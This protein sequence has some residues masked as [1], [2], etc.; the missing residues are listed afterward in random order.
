ML[1]VR[2]LLAGGRSYS[3]HRG[4]VLAVSCPE[5]RHS[6][7]IQGAPNE[8][9][10]ATEQ[11]QEGGGGG[12]VGCTGLSPYSARWPL[13]WCWVAVRWT[14][15]R[16]PQHTQARC[17]CRMSAQN[18]RDFGSILTTS[19]S[20]GSDGLIRPS[21][22]SSI[23]IKVRTMHSRLLWKALRR[24]IDRNVQKLQRP[25]TTNTSEGLIA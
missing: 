5:L 25:S 4:G 16:T 19:I 10:R 9:K 20:C 8:E 23:S 18:I 17:H 3:H 24:T 11:N 13:C 15:D 22:T 2:Y 14:Q 21:P 12:Y 1:I 6:R 7:H